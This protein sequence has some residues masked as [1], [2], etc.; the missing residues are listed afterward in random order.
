M[1]WNKKLCFKT[2]YSCIMSHAETVI[3]LVYHLP[4]KE[5]IMTI[6]WNTLRG[7]SKF[8]IKMFYDNGFIHRPVLFRSLFVHE[9]YFS[10]LKNDYIFEYVH[11]IL[12]LAVF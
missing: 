4:K 10:K 7:H 3:F 1:V 9:T 5:F 12:N 8:R 6:Q 11:L 2:R